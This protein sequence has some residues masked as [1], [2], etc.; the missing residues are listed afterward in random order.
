M[1]HTCR[2]TLGFYYFLIS[3]ICIPLDD[4]MDVDVWA[5]LIFGFISGVLLTS[6]C[7]YLGD[8]DIWD[9]AY[10]IREGAGCSCDVI[11]NIN[12]SRACHNNTV[13]LLLWCNI[14]FKT[15]EC[16]SCALIWRCW[17]SVITVWLVEKWG[18][19]RQMEKERQCNI[20]K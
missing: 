5:L 15:S 7:W 12:K 11:H 9:V 18:K 16:E 2:L 17:W 3:E 8:V 10:I 6:G 4:T 20:N 19:L 1:N 14:L 13:T